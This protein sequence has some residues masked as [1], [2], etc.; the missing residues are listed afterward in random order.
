MQSVWTKVSIKKQPIRRINRHSIGG[1]ANLNF[2]LSNVVHMT[3]FFGA[4]LEKYIRHYAR[5]ATKWPEHGIVTFSDT[6][7]FHSRPKK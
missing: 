5:E 7:G 2:Y 4:H 3:P 1:R 6:R